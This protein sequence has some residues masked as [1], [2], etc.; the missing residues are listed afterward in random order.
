MRRIC[1]KI[2]NALGQGAPVHIESVLI[3]ILH[4]SKHTSKIVTPD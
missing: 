2:L 4:G 3:A 1:M